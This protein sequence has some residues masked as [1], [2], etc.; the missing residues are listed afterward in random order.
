M[1]ARFAAILTMLVVSAC[2]SGGATPEATGATAAAAHSNP[3]VRQG[4]VTTVYVG[5]KMPAGITETP[6]DSQPLRYVEHRY[7]DPS[8]SIAP[9]AVA[10]SRPAFPIEYLL[11]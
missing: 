5:L 11:G 3:T 1:R 10:S 2:Q 7:A 6:Y 9:A 4:T 8:A